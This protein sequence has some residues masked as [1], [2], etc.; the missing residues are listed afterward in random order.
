MA[1]HNPLS[2]GEEQSASLPT[3]FIEVLVANQTKELEV[4]ARELELHR[5]TDRHNFEYAQAALAAQVQ[6]RQAERESR[7]KSKVHTYIFV[8]FVILLVIALVSIALWL[9]KDQVALEVIKAIVYLLSGGGAGYA[10][11]KTGK[12]LSPDTTSG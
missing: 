6:D 8:S 9:N 1:N 12:P 3:Q 2:T 11:G 5:Q 10:I 4:R 7:R